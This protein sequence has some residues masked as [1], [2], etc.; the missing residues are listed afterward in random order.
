MMNSAS[1]ARFCR[2]PILFGVVS[3][4]VAVSAGPVFADAAGNGCA[5]GPAVYRVSSSV[6]KPDSVA[7][8]P[9]AA[10]PVEG[11]LLT[12][13]AA[14]LD[15]PMAPRSPDGE[16]VLSDTLIDQ[17]GGWFTLVF[18]ECGEVPTVWSSPVA[19]EFRP[20]EPAP[21]VSAV[22]VAP[23]L[24]SSTVAPAS[25]SKVVRAPRARQARRS[26][27]SHRTAPMS[28]VRVSNIR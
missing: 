17:V 16:K 23:Q 22:P 6:R 26:R 25:Q 3:A 24:S 27:S 2:F 13:S 8:G 10:F 14:N 1:R 12:V 20:D 19:P 11:S 4:G 7:G 9:L 15:A 18:V 5:D 28:T 21:V